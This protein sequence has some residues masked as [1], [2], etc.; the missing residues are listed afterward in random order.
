MVKKDDSMPEL[1]FY[2]RAGYLAKRGNPV[3]CR[4]CNLKLV[5]VKQARIC[6]TCDN[7]VKEKKRG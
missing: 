7:P 4:W 1:G 2:T 5:V 6:T 3:F